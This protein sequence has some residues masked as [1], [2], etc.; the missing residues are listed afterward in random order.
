TDNIN[1][2]SI[3]YNNRLIFYSVVPNLGYTFF[4][5]IQLNDGKLYILSSSQLNSWGKTGGQ[6]IPQAHTHEIKNIP[7]QGRDS[8]ILYGTRKIVNSNGSETYPLN[9]AGTTDLTIYPP[10]LTVSLQEFYIPVE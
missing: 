9:N 10:S 3:A 2:L 8:I 4:R 1:D 5:P 6:L 7:K